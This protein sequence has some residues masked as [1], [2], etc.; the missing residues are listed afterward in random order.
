MSVP[1][2]TVV[3]EFY[4]DSGLTKRV[5]SVQNDMP[6]NVGTTKT[7]IF[8]I[9]NAIVDE[10]RNISFFSDDKDITFIP[11]TIPLLLPNQSVKIE[12]IWSPPIERRNPLNCKLSA[13]CQ[14]VIKP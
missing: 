12:I 10:L 7:F 11:K 14:V 3:L 2:S 4:E 5:Y 1:I 6:V 8:Y 9:K 13:Y